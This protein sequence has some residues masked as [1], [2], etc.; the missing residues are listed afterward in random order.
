MS[1][2]HKLI[3]KLPF[4][5]YPVIKQ[6]DQVDCGPAALLSIL[7]YYGGSTS[8][9]HLRELTNTGVNGST[10]LDLVYTAK[11]IGFDAFGASGEYEDLMKEQ[12]PCIAHVIVD[13]ILQHFVVV[14]KINNKEVLIGDPG[15]GLYKLSKEKFLEIWQ[16]KAAVLLKPGKE[17]LNKKTITW[18]NWIIAYIKKDNAWLIQSVFLGIIYTILGLLTSVFIQKLVDKYIPEKNT[19]WIYY[20]GIFLFILLLIKASSGFIR[21]K[22]L[23][24]LNKR[25]NNNITG[26]F[27]EHLFNLP[28]KFFDTRK[29]GDITARIH[30]AM[31]IQQAVLQI[32]GVTIVDILIIVG[33]FSLLFYF[34]AYMA[35]I[36]VVVFP[37]Y[38][39]LLFMSTKKLKLEQNDVM[40]NYAQVESAYIDT[41]GGIE[42]IKSYNTAPFYS[43]YNK[44]FFGLFQNCVEKLGLTQAKLNLFAELSSTGITV[45]M[46]LFG[47]VWVAIGDLKL[48]EMMA[49]YSLA[50][51]I[52][53]SINRLI[54]AN[55]SLQSANIAATRLM[56]LLL[57]NKEENE[58][59]NSFIMKEGLSINQA[60][61]SWNNRQ[62]LFD[63]LNIEIPVGKIT[64]L[65]GPSG[66]GKSTLVQLLQRKYDLNKGKI[67]VDGIDSKEIELTSYRKNIGVLPQHIKI[68]N[69]T[70]AE[71]LLV[72]R[73]TKD[74]GELITL[75]RETNLALFI[76]RFEHGL[77]TLLGENGRKLSGGE[78]QMLALIRALLDKP[79]VL[80]ID[81]GLSGVDFEIEEMIYER[82]REYSK[83]NAVLLIT[84]NLANL[85]KT[86]YLY[87]IREGKIYEQGA[88]DILLQNG[89]LFGTSI[90][91]QY[92]YFYENGV[93]VK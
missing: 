34:S 11:E 40:K 46:I 82:I 28:K 25:I 58:T 27:F 30:D 73:E 64:S 2:V 33:S 16:S 89:S 31:R 65:W 41:L 80:I 7:Q 66:A 22:F 61:Y 26:D 6:Y 83:E 55:I 88:P 77:Y 49:S 19:E 71:N 62:F 29:R 59:K 74:A 10:M 38:G 69:G 44:A 67:L 37:I 75:I 53:P 50:V 45:G 20:T 93:V 39:L 23:V 15:K 90:K 86:D 85:L 24:I 5:K 52:L 1:F 84:H 57:V 36:A 92:S 18:F 78:M 79:K 42:D 76:N 47:A 87:V 13:K 48:G 17:L 43:K 60:A 21:D 9:V 54:S 12:M 35:V 4:K 3:K 14:Y 56:D 32:G 51:G 63:D 81:E 70:L 68:F 91:K 8:L 72:G